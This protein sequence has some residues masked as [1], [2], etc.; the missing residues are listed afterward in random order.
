MNYA[1]V[2]QERAINGLG[3]NYTPTE[4]SR[5]ARLEQAVGMPA[6]TIA[7]G[8]EKVLSVGGTPYALEQ[9]QAQLYSLLTSL[10]MPEIGVNVDKVE[11]A[12]TKLAEGD[13]SLDDA[14]QTIFEQIKEAYL[15]ALSKGKGE[16][17]IQAFKANVPS[18]WGDFYNLISSF[19]YQYGITGEEGKKTMREGKG[20]SGLMALKSS[21]VSANPNQDEAN[22]VWKDFEEVVSALKEAVK[23]DLIANLSTVIGLLIT[24]LKDVLHVRERKIEFNEKQNKWTEEFKD[25]SARDVVQYMLMHPE[26]SGD[27]KSALLGVATSKSKGTDI[28]NKMIRVQQAF[29]MPEDTPD[30][31]DKKLKAIRNVFEENFGTVTIGLFD[32]LRLAK[33]KYNDAM[34]YEYL[35]E[36]GLAHLYPDFEKIYG[37]DASEVKAKAKKQIPEAQLKTTSNSP[38]GYAVPSYENSMLYP[39]L[40]R[41]VNSGEYATVTIKVEDRNGE[42]TLGDIQFGKGVQSGND[43]ILSLSD[44]GRGFEFSQIAGMIQ[45]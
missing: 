3:L 14:Y 36:A 4:M 17:F 13:I 35:E 41:A 32:A 10:S 6:G 20:F 43:V 1:S 29:E 12:F 40:E 21:Q 16:D 28:P 11:E 24:W 31:R 27:D 44:D 45:V 15:N 38:F 23:L 26:L 42:R 7:G 25:K 19:A 18:E 8:A 39:E 33:T 5:F 2:Y 9:N 22:Q 37:E 30:K 34:F